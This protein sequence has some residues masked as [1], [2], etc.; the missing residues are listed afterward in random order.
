M[1]VKMTIIPSLPKLESP[2]A[3]V[4]VSDEEVQ[5]VVLVSRFVVGE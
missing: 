5:D 3:P 2:F 1:P 4:R